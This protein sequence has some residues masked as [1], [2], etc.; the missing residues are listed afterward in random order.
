MNMKG[1][2]NNQINNLREMNQKLKSLLPQTFIYTQQE[3]KL[4]LNNVMP[5]ADLK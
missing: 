4:G 5:V 2:K 1:K 3:Y